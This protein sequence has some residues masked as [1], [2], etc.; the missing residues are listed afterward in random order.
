[1]CS[2]R[3]IHYGHPGGMVDL[4][5]RMSCHRQPAGRAAWPLSDAGDGGLFVPC[6]QENG[7]T[8]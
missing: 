3:D 8:V 7:G 4:V 5:A 1:M 2:C 6:E